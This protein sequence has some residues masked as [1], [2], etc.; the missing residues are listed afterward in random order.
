[1]RFYTLYGRPHFVHGLNG[2]LV[3]SFGICLQE[4]VTLLIE[5]RNE[6]PVSESES[7]IYKFTVGVCMM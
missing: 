6:P 3:F 7:Y 5:N 1:M 2:C 4:T